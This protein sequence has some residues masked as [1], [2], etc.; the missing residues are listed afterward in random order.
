[1]TTTPSPNIDQD[2]RDAIARR[3]DETLMVEAG[4]G[5]GKTTSLVRRV[6]ALVAGGHTTMDKIAAITFTEAAAAELQERIREELEKA[7]ASPVLSHEERARCMQGLRDLDRAAVQ[8]L[9]S[10]AG[11]ILRE[12]PLEAGLPPG[13]EVQ[14]E[15]AAGLLFDETWDAWLDAA[16]DAPALQDPFRAALSLGLSL[17]DLKAVAREFHRNHD[18]LR[19]AALPPAPL[20]ARRAAQRIRERAGE[21]ERLLRYA[22]NSEADPLVAHTRTVLT[23]ARRLETAATPVEEWRLLARKGPIKTTRGNRKDWESD[24]RSPTRENACAALKGLLEDLDAVAQQELA[25]ARRA[26]LLPL[27]SAVRDFVLAYEKVRKADGRA[28]FHDLLVWARD[29]LASDLSVRDQFRARYSHILIDE[30]QDTD[31]VQAEIAIFLAEDAA[32]TPPGGARPARWQD[33]TVQRGKLFVVGDPKQSIYRFRRAEVSLM[34][35]LQARLG[36]QPALLV[37]NFRSQRPVLEWVNT[38]F[39]GWMADGS[40]QPPYA[41]LAHSRD[42]QPDHPTQPGVHVIGD[43]LAVPAD[44]MR[45]NEAHDIAALVRQIRAQQWPVTRKDTPDVFPAAYRDICILLPVRTGLQVLE[46]ALEDARVPYRLESASLVFDTQEVRDLLNCLRAIDSPADQVALVAALRSPAF[47]CS[48]V[49]LLRFVEDGGKLDYLSPGAAPDGPVTAALVS[50]REYHQRRLWTTPAALITQVVRETRL[51]EAALDRPRPRERWRRYDFLVERARAFAE[52]GGTSLRDFVAWADGQREEGARVAEVPVPETDEDAV[53][54]M[55]VH[56][57][58]GLEFPIVILTGINSAGS[59]KGRAVL[60]DR[61]TGA[62]EV[63]VGPKNAPFQ[64]QGYDALAQAEDRREEEEDVRLMYVAATRARDHLVVSLFRTA[65][66]KGSFAYEIAARLG[67]RPDL[68]RRL[69][70]EEAAAPDDAVPPSGQDIAEDTPEARAA[71]VE[72]WRRDLARSARPASVAATT[73]AHDAKEERE[74][75]DEPWRRGRGGTSLGRAVHAVLQTVDLA[76][77]QGV[78]E[79]ARAQAAAEGIPHR[80]DEVERLARVALGM[81]SVRRAVASARWWRETPVAAPVQGGLLEGFIDLLFEERDG[82]GIVD[83][84]TDA[85]R[86]DAEIGAAMERYRLQ[87]GAYALALEKATDLSVKEVVFLFLQPAREVVVRGLAEV[88][89]QARR[90]AEEAFTT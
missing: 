81:A 17:G 11:S 84:K 13:F 1:M 61:D 24:R 55:T 68:W 38:L 28:E 74:E 51:M 34:A 37:Q 46:D 49:D 60:F 72:T 40:G 48:D 70:V 75:P 2:A 73:L 58:K 76:S 59:H 41:H 56:A 31:P 12:R 80:A 88:K 5:T 42:H 25:E 83:Y 30:V 87:G 15:I 43:A 39:S 19:A 57:S 54:I 18:L 4:A 36:V 29:L 82:L 9:H 62:A 63:R 27:L 8:T 71:W 10:F 20:P 45:R 14:D 66:D 33:V 3:L 47:A 6:V 50:L 26:A 86:S 69:E 89:E 7:A 22:K 79:T 35:Q 23:L 67:H 90:A 77:G 78:R 64:T 16:L 65:R 52:A 21:M 53:R 32:Q 85:L 44:R